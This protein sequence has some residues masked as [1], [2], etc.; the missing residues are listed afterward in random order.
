MPSENGNDSFV[1]EDFK[2]A[3][4]E[5]K[6]KCNSSLNEEEVRVAVNGF[7]DKIIDSSEIDITRHNE[8]TLLKGGR[9]DSIYNNILFELKAPDL[10]NSTNGKKEAI[11]GRDERDRGLFHYLVNSSIENNNID[12]DYFKYLITKKIGVGFDGKKFIFCRFRE[13]DN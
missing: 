11:Y 10:F 6:R 1:E 9:V 3:K 5:F 8:F 13:S 2:E 7:L 4:K 12:D